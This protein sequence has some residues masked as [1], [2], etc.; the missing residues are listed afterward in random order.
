MTTESWRVVTESDEVA[1]VA[2]E[3][4]GSVGDGR[5]QYIVD[6]VYLVSASARDAVARYAVWDDARVG[7]A[8]A[9][10]EILAPGVATRAEAVAAESERCARLADAAA[11]RWST[12]APGERVLADDRRERGNEAAALAAEIRGGAR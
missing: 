6:G 11:A 8:L 9:V 10:T 3:D 5:R 2:V 12:L 4:R 1:S 7:G